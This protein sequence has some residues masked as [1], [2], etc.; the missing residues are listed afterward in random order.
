MLDESRTPT[1]FLTVHIF[2]ILFKSVYLGST[3][4]FS[5]Q[6]KVTGRAAALNNLRT[7]PK[8]HYMYSQKRNYAASVPSP[9]VMCLG[10]LYIPRIG[11]HIWLQQNRQPNPGNMYIS[12]SYTSVGIGRQSIT[13]LFWK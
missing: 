7:V 11:P 2:I 13:I 12:Q 5:M 6:R 4:L 1:L 9:T 10:D 3:P 8:I